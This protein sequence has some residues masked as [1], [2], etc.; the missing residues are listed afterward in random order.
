MR[1]VGQTDEGL[2]AGVVELVLHLPRGIQRVGVD[3]HQSGT[4]GAEHRN[5]KLDQ[6]GQLDGDAIARRQIGVLLQPGGKGAGQF[7]EL[8]VAEGA[9]EVAEGRLVGKALTGFAQHREDV[10][11]AVGI[12]FGC[13]PCRVLVRPEAFGHRDSPERLRLSTAAGT[14]LRVASPAVALC[15]VWPAPARVASS[16]R[17]SGVSR[18]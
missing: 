13:D 8:A 3:H 14:Q 1:H 12:D 7:I 16:G 11:I 6:V 17:L 15:Y 5:G 4:Q 2:G 18:G 10:R 9:A